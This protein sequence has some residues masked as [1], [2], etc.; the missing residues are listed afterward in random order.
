MIQ[1]FNADKAFLGADC[2]DVR[3]GLTTVSIAAG[4]RARHG[5][6]HPREVVVL[7][8]HSKFE[9]VGPAAICPLDQIEWW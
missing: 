8:D 7:A 1:Q 9:R 2:I 6:A 4:P 5:A 3:A